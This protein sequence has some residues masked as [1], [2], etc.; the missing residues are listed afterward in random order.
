MKEFNNYS[1]ISRLVADELQSIRYGLSYADSWANN[2]LPEE[3]LDLLGEDEWGNR[4]IP[5][6][7]GNDVNDDTYHDI[8][9]EWWRNLSLNNKIELIDNAIILAD[10]ELDIEGAASAPR[11]IVESVY[12]DIMSSYTLRNYVDKFHIIHFI[13]S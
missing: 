9:V 3:I 12:D 11:C 4:W 13:L 10:D 1:I 6:N 2:N 8:V 5:H 7:C